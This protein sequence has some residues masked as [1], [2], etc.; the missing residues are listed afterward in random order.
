MLKSKNRTE[1]KKARKINSGMIKQFVKQ[2]D[3][4]QVPAICIAVIVICLAALVR[5]NGSH[6]RSINCV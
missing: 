1:R 2:I 5:V 3:K 6:F 4:K